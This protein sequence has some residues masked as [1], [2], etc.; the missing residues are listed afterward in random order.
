VKAANL[1]AE[2][3]L[4]R[5][6]PN[7]V[8][9][10]LH[11]L[12][13]IFNYAK[14]E[15]YI[16]W[17][18]A[19]R[20]ADGLVQSGKRGNRRPYSLQQLQR[21]FSAPLY[22]G[23]QNDQAGYATVGPNHPR[24]GRFWVPLIALFGGL[25][26]NEACQLR[27]ADVQ[28]RDGVWCMVVQND[29]DDGQDDRRI[30]TAAGQR[31]VPIHPEL[32]KIGFLGHVKA[33][34]TAG[35]ERLFPELPKGATGYFSD[36]FQKWWGRFV[37]KAGAAAPKTSFHSFRHCF[38]DAQREA[39]LSPDLVRALGGWAPPG[40]A[41]EL[42]GQGVRPRT[43]YEAISRLSYPGLDLSPLYVHAPSK[44]CADLGE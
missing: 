3:G 24:R 36:P 44:G 21:I 31:V 6:S 37:Q 43:L 39:G 11:N 10:Y 28:E 4:K 18:P 7:T 29:P 32:I 38:R 9:F 16:S 13:A 26:S 1:A 17:N 20:L 12:S 8:K 33:M 15:G 19:E 34:R 30:K 14:R 23:C 41:E 5:I 35:E 42:Y 22:T 2:T 40:G 27:V 25:R